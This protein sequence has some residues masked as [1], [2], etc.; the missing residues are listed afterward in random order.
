[1]LAK[2]NVLYFITKLRRNKRGDKVGYA[3]V[4]MMKIK[5]GAIGG[6]QSHN[7]REHEPKTNPDV[8]MS[9]SEDNYDLVPCSNYKK[10]IKEKLSNLVKSSRAIRK[11]AVVVCNFIVT[12]D[13]ATMEALGVDRQ[14][15]FFEDSVKWFSDRYGAD[16]IL[17]ATV[18]MDE[19][20]PHL[21]VGVVPITQD[22]RLSAKAIF[23]KTEMKAIQ[24]EFARDVGEKYGLERGV[25]GSERTHLSEARF[26]EKKALEMANEYGEIAQ[27]LQTVTDNCKQEL[28]EASRSLEMVK[29]EL[30][31]IQE[32]RDALQ[33]EIEG[34][35]KDLLA[36]EQVK[37]VP[38][39][40]ALIGDR[41][42]VATE[43]FEALCRTAATAEALLKEIIPARR[44]NSQAKELIQQ[45]K[46]NAAAILAEAKQYSLKAAMDRASKAADFERL[47]SHLESTLKL[48]SAESKREFVSAW[49]KVAQKG[50]QKSA[51]D[52]ER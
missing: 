19:T 4:H 24:T 27:E 25:E 39:V 1:L 30:S 38:H 34:L 17:N 18:H 46:D 15:K 35:Q 22:G 12:S 5:S 10:S 51:P 29:R 50:H 21:H 42:V 32:K 36:T 8:D 13:N 11:D 23:T 44:I 33:S 52:L 20:T 26:K 40:K 3:V 9:R 31:T 7:N 28:S 49:K 16:R 43:D 37:D 45:A 47:N 2:Y 48:L 6:I 41:Q 14:R